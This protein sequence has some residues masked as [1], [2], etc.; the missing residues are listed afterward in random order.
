MNFIMFMFNIV[1]VWTHLRN[2]FIVYLWCHLLNASISILFFTRITCILF[3]HSI[4]LP[5][6]YTFN[7]HFLSFLNLCL[8]KW[9]KT[10]LYLSNS[11]K[12]P[13]KIHSE[14][15]NAVICILAPV[16]IDL[17][18]TLSSEPNLLQNSTF[19]SFWPSLYSR[20]GKR[21]LTSTIEFNQ[22]PRNNLRNLRKVYSS[23]SCLEADIWP[24]VGQSSAWSPNITPLE[25]VILG[26]R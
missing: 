23:H 8:A 21:S 6:K 1:L 19:C 9:P 12:T 22:V 14:T 24:Y 5:L 26:L 10:N 3:R 15:K 13:S 16:S 25:I 2:S 4:S 11:F 17:A 20:E 18:R 7:L